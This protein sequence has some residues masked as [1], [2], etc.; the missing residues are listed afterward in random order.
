MPTENDKP[1]A[2]PVAAPAAPDTRDARI[3]S[4]EDEVTKLQNKLDAANKK[5]K[6]KAPAAPTGNYCVLNGKTY[7]VERTVE[8]KFATDEAR[9]GYIDLDAELVVLKR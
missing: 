1:K 7:E 4:L 8:A 5:L 6:E 2:T 3:K 9:K